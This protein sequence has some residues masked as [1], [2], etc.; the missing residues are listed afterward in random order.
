MNHRMESR[1]T[2]DQSVASIT[3]TNLLWTLR[4]VKTV[5]TTLPVWD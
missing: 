2:V 3:A 1:A 4:P 5:S